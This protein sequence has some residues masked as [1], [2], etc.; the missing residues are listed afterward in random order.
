[1]FSYCFSWQ[2]KLGTFP[3]PGWVIMAVSL[4]SKPYFG[5]G[6]QRESSVLPDEVKVIEEPPK[7][8]VLPLWYK[9]LITSSK[10]FV[11]M[12]YNSYYVVAKSTSCLEY[13]PKSL[14]FSA[15]N[16]LQLLLETVIS[17]RSTSSW[18][19]CICNGIH[20]C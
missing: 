11:Q 17:Q 6:L 9:L 14:Q 4:F 16:V 19:C 18:Q 8:P 2:R 7:P 20:V 5:N 3:M 12:L 13:I 1:M 10:P 15:Q